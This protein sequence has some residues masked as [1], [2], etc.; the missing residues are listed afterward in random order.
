M[1]PVWFPPNHNSD[2]FDG[3]PDGFDPYVRPED[4]RDPD[5]WIIKLSGAGSGIKLQE[6]VTITI[7]PK[8]HDFLMKY[9]YMKDLHFG[10]LGKLSL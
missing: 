5:S 8:I 9:R 2:Q 1:K 7:N 6:E 3:I 10:K 4:G